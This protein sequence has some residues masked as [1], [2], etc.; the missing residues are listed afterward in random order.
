MLVAIHKKSEQRVKAIEYDTAHAL[1]S[2]FPPEELVCPF[3]EE[4]VFPRE[5]KGFVLHFG[6]C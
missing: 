5:R 2:K 6:Y 3:C 1:R 4:M